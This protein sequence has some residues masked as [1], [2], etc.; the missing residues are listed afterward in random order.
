[1]SKKQKKEILSKTEPAVQVKALFLESP[2]RTF[3]AR[4]IAGM[5]RR[6]DDESERLLDD[7]L[8]RLVESGFLTVSGE[9][10]YRL[11]RMEEALKEGVVVTLGQAVG[12]V[13]ADGYDEDLVVTPENRMNALVGDRVGIVVLPKRRRGRLECVVE[14]I[15]ER[16]TTRFVGTAKV[17]SVYTFVVPDNRHMPAD[18]CVEPKDNLGAKTGDK[19][20][21]EL[22]DWPSRNKNPNGRIVTVFGPAGENNAEMH[23]ILAEYGLPGHFAPE[24]E[25]AANGIGDAIPAAER[26]KRRDFTGVPTFTIDPADAKD[27]DDALSIRKVREGVWEVGVHIA[28]V[29]YYVRED[30]VLDREA[31]ERATSV[32]LVDRVVP[33][34]PE[35]L[36]NELC[37]LRPNEEKLCFSA[38]FELNEEGEV[39]Q[40]WFGRTVIHSDRRFSYEEAQQ[41]IETGI[42]DMH[43]EIVTLNRLA[44]VLRAARY[45]NGSIAFERDE[46]KFRLDE[47]GK[48][49]GVYFKEI[50]ES[51][52]LI[53][54]FMLLAN[55]KVAE[56]VG[57]KRGGRRKERTFVYRVHDKPNEQKFNDFCAFIAKFGY[58]MRAKTDRAI[59]REMNKLLA[60]I[61]GR[62][63]ENLFSVLA[64]RSM[65]KAVYSTDNIGHY[66]LAFDY[67]THFTSPIRRY[68]D[69]M[70]HRLLQHYLDGG[71]S[72]DKEFY[73]ELCRHSSDREVRA[74]E[75]ERSSVKYKMVEFMM[76]KIGEEFDGYISGITE[77]GV[78]VE[79]EQ[80]KIEGMVS[81]RDMHDD[82]YA[83]D[84]DNY[85]LI[86]MNKKRILTLGDPV[87]IRVLR[88]DLQRKQIDYELTAHT[89]LSSGKR[90]RFETVKNKEVKV[91]KKGNIVTEK[92]SGRRKRR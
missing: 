53:E 35:R 19:V 66:G 40:E 26:K 17:S 80:T 46:V 62:K 87:S 55:R 75:A 16:K 61:K 10:R 13:K 44:C 4:Q 50:K 39:L 41:I 42:G 56:F 5:F 48:P 73:E 57:R 78:Y 14:K 7:T 71:A 45:K 52:H 38:V 72:A 27:F 67:Y 15:I 85:R 22:I 33:M 89:D 92:P 12:Y 76:D 49:L 23:A 11:G 47:N 21:V 28:D 88:C 31:R 84:A 29:T 63:E 74:T 43:R 91:G 36:S 54:E 3:T 2:F 58:T 32:Y 82:H 30:S 37:S 70:V 34:L 81:V 9:S 86:G 1:M 6:M 65:A 60:K 64:L 25:A 68:P 69:M 18:F 90:S 20:L 8:Q 83:Y 77:W 79:L 59:A 51:N 24:V